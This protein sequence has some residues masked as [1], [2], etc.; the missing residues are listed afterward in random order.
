MNFEHILENF[1]SKLSNKFGKNKKQ[2]APKANPMDSANNEIDELLHNPSR[3]GQL[4]AEQSFAHELSSIL[5]RKIDGKSV[6]QALNPQELT[7]FFIS[8]RDKMMSYTTSLYENVKTDKQREKFDKITT[9]LIGETMT[10]IGLVQR[11]FLSQ[12]QKEKESELSQLKDD[13]DKAGK[14]LDK[15]TKKVD[16]LKKE[17][18]DTQ[19]EIEDAENILAE[20]KAK[21]AEALNAASTEATA[22]QGRLADEIADEREAIAKITK[23]SSELGATIAGLIED[24]NGKKTENH[25]LNSQAAGLQ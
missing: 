24:L 22:T 20:R 9:Y 16:G 7:E 11:Y 3:M 25:K 13:H 23:E 14:N 6:G 4:V 2:P 1:K 8:I 12:A 17:I 5:R 10:T 19:K 21:S 15:I 18:E